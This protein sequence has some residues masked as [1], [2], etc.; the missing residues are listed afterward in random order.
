MQNNKQEKMKHMSFVLP[1]E[2]R[3]AFKY[4]CLAWELSPSEALRIMVRLALG[5]HYDMTA[6]KQGGKQ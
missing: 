1:Q 6:A 3:R 2:E 5:G 4:L